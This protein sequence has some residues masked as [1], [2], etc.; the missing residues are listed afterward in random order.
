MYSRNEVELTIMNRVFFCSFRLFIP[1][2]GSVKY[3]PIASNASRIVYQ[4]HGPNEG[5]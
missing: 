4:S 3:N 2:G 1:P 5:T